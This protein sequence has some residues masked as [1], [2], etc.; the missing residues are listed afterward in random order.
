MN[1]REFLQKL[2]EYLSYE[3]PAR[4]IEKNIR[5]YDEYIDGEVGHGRSAAE[6]IEELGDPQLIAKSITDSIKAG[7]DGIPNSEDDVDFTEE[8]YENGGPEASQRAF[9]YRGSSSYSEGGP[10]ASDNKFGPDG[11]NEQPDIN[12]PFGGWHVYSTGGSGCLFLTILICLVIFS[13]FSLL[14]AVLGAISPVLAPVF[15]AFLIL[16]LLERR[17]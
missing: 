9:R 16:W 12:N 11:T 13:L 7:A 4:Y 10:G 6:V 2:R 1:K 3:L 5:Y 8:I 15:I 14:G 17:R